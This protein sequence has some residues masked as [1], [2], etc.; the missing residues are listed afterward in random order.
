MTDVHTL[1]LP[2]HRVNALAVETGK[3]PEV[4]IAELLSVLHSRKMWAHL[5]GEHIGESVFV[6]GRNVPTSLKRTS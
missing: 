5:R 6:Y 4:A 1:T 2:T 3:D